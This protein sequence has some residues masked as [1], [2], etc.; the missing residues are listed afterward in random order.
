MDQLDLA[1]AVGALAL[2]FFDGGGGGLPLA[3][4]IAVAAEQDRC[5]AGGGDD[6]IQYRGDVPDRGVVPELE[7]VWLE[8]A[9]EGMAGVAGDEVEF[10]HA[11]R[12][13][14]DGVAGEAVAARG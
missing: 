2:G 12:V 1:K 3:L 5:P 4:P 11:A 14:G 6:R 13:D 8:V 9:H 10:A 7:V